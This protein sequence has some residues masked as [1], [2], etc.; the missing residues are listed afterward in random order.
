MG[1][2]IN[3]K[4]RSKEQWLA[5]NGEKVVG[6][7]PSMTERPGFLPVCLVDNGP[8][9]AAAIAYQQRELEA[10]VEPDDL[11]RKTWFLVEQTK[12]LDV[13]DLARVLR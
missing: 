10:F 3:P 12:L 13:S 9:T 5:E 6:R 7:V 8:F 11:R 4:D 2:Y 1:I